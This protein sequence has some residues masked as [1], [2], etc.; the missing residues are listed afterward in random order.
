V[1]FKAKVALAA[2]KSLLLRRQGATGPSPSWRARTRF[3]RTR[4]PTGR[5]SCWTAQ[6]VCL[7]AAGAAE[8]TASAAQ[9]DL[10]YRQIGQLKVEND[11]YEGLGEGINCHEPAAFSVERGRSTLCSPCAWRINLYP[12]AL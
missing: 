4:S 2:I 9:V 5:S 6:R 10:L 1:A 8:G 7:R 12:A 3:T 11:L